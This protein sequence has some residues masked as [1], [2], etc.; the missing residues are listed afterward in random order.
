[1][2]S[3]LGHPAGRTATGPDLSHRAEVLPAAVRRVVTYGSR[4]RG[5][6]GVVFRVSSFGCRLSGVAS[7]GSSL[8]EGVV[9]H[10]VVGRGAIARAGARV[11]SLT[12]AVVTPAPPRLSHLDRPVLGESTSARRR[13]GARLVPAWSWSRSRSSW[14]RSGTHPD[15]CDL[16]R[17]RGPVRN[18]HRDTS[19]QRQKHHLSPG[20]D[21]SVDMSGNT[22]HR[23]D[24]SPPPRPHT[25]RT[26]RP[27]A[28]S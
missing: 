22:H 20:P 28:S 18:Q 12:G 11:L 24:P 6:T 27:A 2:A 17:H 7:C 9:S 1:M 13:P 15:E 25:P 21:M 8:F 16:H 3:F 14:G 23:T 5:L 10:G 19:V 4:G 26:R